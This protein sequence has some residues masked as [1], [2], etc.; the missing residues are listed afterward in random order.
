MTISGFV[1][2]DI[3]EEQLGR[4]IKQSRF[5]FRITKEVEEIIYN[6]NSQAR[7]LTC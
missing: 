6:Q 5:F 1:F 3:D 4:T 7:L 2:F